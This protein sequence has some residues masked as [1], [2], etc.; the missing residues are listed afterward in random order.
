[1]EKIKWDLEKDKFLP[2]VKSVLICQNC[3]WLITN[4][5]IKSDRDKGIDDRD[6]C[7]NCLVRITS[8]IQEIKKEKGKK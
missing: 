1:M 4:P 8:A 2:E 5:H 3:G 7:P 6:E